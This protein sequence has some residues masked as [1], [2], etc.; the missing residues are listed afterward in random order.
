MP[1]QVETAEHV[2]I[3]CHFRFRVD[4]LHALLRA[5]AA[6]VGVFEGGEDVGEKGRGPED[7]VVTEDCDGCVYLED[8]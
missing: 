4:P 3:V 5:D 2:E 7:V 8:R 1:H 6:H